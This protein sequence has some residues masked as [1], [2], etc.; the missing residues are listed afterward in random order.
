MWIARTIYFR[1]FKAARQICVVFASV[2]SSLFLFFSSPFLFKR[3]FFPFWFAN[4]KNHNRF[5]IWDAMNQNAS[6]QFAHFFSV[7]FIYL[8]LTLSFVW[9]RF[10]CCCC[11]FDGGYL[12]HPHTF[13]KHK[14][15]SI[16]YQRR[17][18]A[19]WFIEDSSSSFLL[20]LVFFAI[21]TE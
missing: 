6:H 9:R 1:L 3:D 10:C 14:T 12:V 19:I 11:C 15:L 13:I 2:R 7:A 21:V 17:A 18:R 20:L 16:F 4:I 5:F 8:Y